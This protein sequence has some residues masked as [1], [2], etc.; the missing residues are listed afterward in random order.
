MRLKHKV[1]FRVD[2]NKEVGLG[3]MKRCQAL[4]TKFHQ[5]GHEVLFAGAI[6]ESFEKLLAE[7]NLEYQC[8]EG[9]TNSK[10]DLLHFLEICKRSNA[11]IVVIDVYA[12]DNHYCQ[13]L[14]DEGY[15]LVAMQ[16]IGVP[17][18]I[19]HM[20]INGNLNAERIFYNVPD[21]VTLRLGIDYLIMPQEYWN[22]KNFKDQGKDLGKVKNILITMGGA[23][24]YD[25][26]TRIL[27]ILN[28][29]QED[30]TLTV[31]IGPYYENQENIV[32]QI[33]RIKKRV[34]LIQSPSSL[35]PY[36][37]DCSMAISS[38]GQTLYQL[39]ALGRPT[40]GIS[41]E[42]NQ[43]SHLKELSSS[44]A[45]IGLIYGKGEAFE[46]DLKNSICE[47]INNFSQ[48]IRLSESAT[49]LVDGQGAERVFKAIINAYHRRENHVLSTKNSHCI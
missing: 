44:G 1:I 12:I 29:I 43:A 14:M 2:A 10:K 11:E 48:R 27:S 28:S 30:F 6:D 25:L 3:H 23:D 39:A 16:D 5:H 34:D 26:T 35:F 24:Q 36:I 40:I 20:I 45:L 49:K 38:A 9:Q 7:L 33:N 42:E 19:V 22:L 4:G 8:I 31:L 47:L 41:L 18:Q 32:S 13:R 21:E 17:T 46:E 37:V 15:Y